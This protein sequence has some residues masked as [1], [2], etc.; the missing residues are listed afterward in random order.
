ML[1]QGKVI[2]EPRTPSI[3]KDFQIRVNLPF[4]TDTNL[5]W[6]Q[7]KWAR[8]LFLNTWCFG[9]NSSLKHVINTHHDKALASRSK[10]SNK[11]ES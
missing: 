8:G 3:M 7:M 1:S 9:V 5:T 6:R 10:G 11:T 4:T 2:T